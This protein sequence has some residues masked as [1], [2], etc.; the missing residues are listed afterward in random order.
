MGAEPIRVELTRYQ[1]LEILRLE[2]EDR[3]KELV[4][5]EKRIREALW[6]MER[7]RFLQRIHPHFQLLKIPE[8]A[9]Q[10]PQL[11][12]YRQ[13]LVQALETLKANIQALEKELGSKGTPP[14]PGQ[15]GPANR[16]VKFDSFEEF[17]NKQ[18]RP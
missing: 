8:A 15:G 11:E 10:V 17:R 2:E 14:S 3:A 5:I 4:E 9:A 7:V 1:Q 13:S 18:S 16:K 12:Q 6:E